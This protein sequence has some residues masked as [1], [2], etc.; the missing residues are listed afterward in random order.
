MK[1]RR[2]LAVLLLVGLFG[3]GCATVRR[4]NVEYEE[5][6]TQEM[7]RVGTMTPEAK[8]EWQQSEHERNKIN[9]NEYIGDSG[10][11]GE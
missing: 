2:A 5:A 1:I 9:W 4:L 10:G 3:P 7:T 11:D 6:T 8:A